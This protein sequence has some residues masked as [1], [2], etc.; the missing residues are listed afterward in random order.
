MK[1]TYHGARRV[2]LNLITRTPLEPVARR[3]YGIILPSKGNIY[4]KQ[5][6]TTMRKMLKENSNCIDVGAYRG[7]ILAQI[8]KISPKGKHFAFEPVP[9][10][11]KYLRTKFPGVKVY[12]LALGS[13]K[14]WTIFNHV[15][16]RAARSG[17]V[18]VEYPDK[19]QEIKEIRI[20]LDTL[21]NVIPK[22]TP[23]DFLKIDVEGGELGVLKGAKKLIKKNKPIIVFEHELEKASRYKTKPA[24]VYELLV[25][26]SGLRIFLMDSFLHGKKPLTRSSFV[27]AVE[28]NSDFYFIA[29]P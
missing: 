10:N 2:A 22:N 19:D 26:E 12:N 3:A 27:R 11:F 15:V 4:D 21:D 29:A 1:V 6:F 24:Q 8:K 16:G 17:L 23:I 5:T 25:K 13:K 9:E 28:R 20:R 7:E 18:R 14:G